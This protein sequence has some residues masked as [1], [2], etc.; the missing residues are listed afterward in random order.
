[1]VGELKKMPEPALQSLTDNKVKVIAAKG[2][3]TDYATDLKGVQPRGWPPGKTWDGVPGVYLPDRNA[4]VIATTGLG[5]DL[6]VP[7]TGEGHGSMN[8][9]VHEASHAIDQ[10]ASALRN[11]ASPDFLAARAKDLANLPSY[12]TQ[13]GIAGPSETYAESAARFYG[14]SH[15]PI[16]TPALDDYWR[17]NAL[18]GK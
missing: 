2:S 18:G 8:V 12:E 7:A 4:V 1:V 15:G 11:S 9:V 13:P 16:T 6:R 17:S 3:I 14:G 10:N 5:A